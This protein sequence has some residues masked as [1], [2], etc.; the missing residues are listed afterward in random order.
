MRKFKKSYLLLGSLALSLSFGTLMSCNT[1]D[2]TVYNSKATLEL[3]GL[4]KLG[5]GKKIQL[6]LKLTNADAGEVTYKSSDETI[7]TVD[8]TG[9]VTGVKAGT[10]KVVA[11]LKTNAVAGQEVLED[12]LTLD[13]VD[14]SELQLQARF[15]DYDGSLLYETK[16]AYGE[17]AEYVGLN[18]KRSADYKN[19]YVFKGWD[20]AL[21]GLTENTTFVA[22][23]STQDIQDFIFT[24]INAGED[25]YMLYMYLGTDVEITVPSS[26]NGKP[27]TM[28]DAAAFSS[29]KLKKITLPDTIGVI[30]DG[31]FRSIYTLEEINI[32]SSVYEFGSRVFYNCTGL[33]KVTLPS[34]MTVLPEETFYYCEGL[35]EITLPEGIKKIE[36]SAF[37]NCYALK[38]VGLP[39]TLTTM[40]TGVFY[41]CESL[42][43]VSIPNSVTEI[44]EQTFYNCEKLVSVDYGTLTTIPKGTFYGCESLPS[45]DFNGITT[46]GVDAFSGAGLKT[47][48]LSDSVTSIER[49]AFGSNASLKSVRYTSSFDAL[50]D[51]MFNGCK[52]LDTLT[53]IDHLTKIGKNSFMQTAFSTVGSNLI[54]PKVTLVDNYA[55]S[56]MPN[57]TEATIPGNVKTVGNGVFR[58]CPKL[59]EVTFSEGVESIGDELFESDVLLTTVNFPAKSL[60]KV[61]TEMF[62]GCTSMEAYTYP[63]TVKDLKIVDGVL[64]N[65][66]KNILL[67]YPCGKKDK[68]YKVPDGCTKISEY[69][70]NKVANLETIDLNGVTE[71]GLQAFVESSLKSV[72]VPKSLVKFSTFSFYKM[73]NLTTAVVEAQLKTVPNGM[74]SLNPLLNSVTLPETVETIEK[75]S[76]NN[77]TSLKSINFS[78]KLKTIKDGAFANDRSLNA[79]YPGTTTQFKSL[80]ISSSAFSSGAKITCNDGVVTY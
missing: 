76:F 75:Y 34:N 14:T 10:A 21:T 45:F 41:G 6:D 73:P 63:E 33:K 24:P 20:K 52:M 69:G 5:V 18:P 62:T 71:L 36:D 48:N 31:A 53:N 77:C 9:L 44:G 58:V 42:E 19:A 56:A 79:T 43:T 61:G 35:E 7:L 15:V 12:E 29:V 46:I 3:S 55:F 16:V 72:T 64:F 37:K 67:S 11:T 49:W 22:Q 50:P 32:P 25:G 80:T 23:Y 4:S 57:I 74:F 1:T 38:S 60:T 54:G 39:S 13:V 28:I 47:L 17:D 59:T 8:A 66:N 27:V 2:T 30:G 70:F 51:S 78:L 68:T 26:Y 40:G 65:T